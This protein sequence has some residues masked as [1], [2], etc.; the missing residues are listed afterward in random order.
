MKIEKLKQL[1]AIAQKTKQIFVATADLAG[2]PHIACAGCANVEGENFLSITEWFCPG[3][4]ANLR[5]NENIAVAAWDKNTDEGYQVIGKLAKIQDV[6]VLDSYAPDIET[7][8]PLPQVER[9]LVIEV[10]KILDFRLGPHT[11]VEE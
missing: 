8:H 10:E 7:R 6:A 2:S 3:T 4:V 9:K 11:D 5:K 1:A